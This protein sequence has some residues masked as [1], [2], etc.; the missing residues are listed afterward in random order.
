MGCC[1]APFL[2]PAPE[3]HICCIGALQG[4]GE[5]PSSSPSRDE[6]P[7]SSI[8][9]VNVVCLLRDLRQSCQ[10]AT[11]AYSTIPSINLSLRFLDMSGHFPLQPGHLLRKFTEV[12]ALAPGTP[13]SALKSQGHFQHMEFP[14]AVGLGSSPAPW[15]VCLEAWVCQEMLWFPSMGVCLSLTIVARGHQ[16]SFSKRLLPDPDE[17]KEGCTPSGMNKYKLPMQR[18]HVLETSLFQKTQTFPFLLYPTARLCRTSK[19]LSGDY[20][21]EKIMFALY[22]DKQSADFCLTHMQKVDIFLIWSRGH[23]LASHY[24]DGKIFLEEKKCE[25]LAVEINNEYQ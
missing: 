9:Q 22:C 25:T 15:E 13:Y 7:L 20:L 1:P 14:T 3:R 17:K 5:T 4:Q 2:F 8:L 11:V 10:Y 23:F 12:D 6:G 21:G 24:D 19:L 18:F 16:I